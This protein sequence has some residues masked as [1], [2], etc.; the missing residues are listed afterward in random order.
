M[1][2]AVK[3]VP[4]SKSEMTAK[5]CSYW[6][7]EDEDGNTDGDEYGHRTSLHHLKVISVGCCNPTSETFISSF[8]IFS[9]TKHGEI[10]VSWQLAAAILSTLACA[11]TILLTPV[12]SFT[13]T[14]VDF[15]RLKYLSQQHEAVTQGSSFLSAS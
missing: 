11:G 1:R 9:P 15:Y 10:C 7:Y 5:N 3:T 4:T 8:C 12:A 13:P 2:V 14:P 6:H